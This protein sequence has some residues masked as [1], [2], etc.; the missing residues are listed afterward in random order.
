MKYISSNKISE[1]YNEQVFHK[2]AVLKNFRRY[3][4]KH[5][6]WSLFLN[7]SSGPQS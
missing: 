1:K 2:K 7:K 6:C 5:L 3:T 4:E